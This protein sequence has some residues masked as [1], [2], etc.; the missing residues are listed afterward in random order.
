MEESKEELQARERK[1][2]GNNLFQ[3]STFTKG[4]EIFE[5]NKFDLVVGNPPW[6]LGKLD[7]GRKRVLN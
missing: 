7:N 1:K 5:N 2:P 3:F 4:L 6:K